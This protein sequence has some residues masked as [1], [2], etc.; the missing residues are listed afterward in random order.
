MGASNVS[1]Q[2]NLLILLKDLTIHN[3]RAMGGKTVCHR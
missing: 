3:K 2:V 1:N